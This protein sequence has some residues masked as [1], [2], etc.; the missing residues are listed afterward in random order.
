MT[1]ART[2]LLLPVLQAWAEGK[3]IEYR[4]VHGTEWVQCRRENEPDF[5]LEGLEWRLKPEPRRFWL[6]LYPG[7]QPAIYGH[8]SQSLADSNSHSGSRSECIEV[9][10]VLK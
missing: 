4:L 1:R 7:A 10:E 6:N 8:E 3:E 2:K 9:V 5:K